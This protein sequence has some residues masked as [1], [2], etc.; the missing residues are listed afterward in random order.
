MITNEQSDL[1]WAEELEFFPKKDIQ[2]A[3]GT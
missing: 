3:T 1:K 2:R